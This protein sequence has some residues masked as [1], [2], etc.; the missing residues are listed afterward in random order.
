MSHYLFYKEVRRLTS[1]HHPRRSPTASSRTPDAT[2][3]SR[4]QFF[5]RF[6]GLPLGRLP[7]GTNSHINASRSP[8]LLNT[9]PNQPVVIFSTVSRI[10]SMLNLPRI[11]ILNTRS[12]TVSSQILLRSTRPHPHNICLSLCVNGHTVPAYYMVRLIQAANT[13]NRYFRGTLLLHNK[14]V[15]I[16]HV[17]KSC[18]I[19]T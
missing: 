8:F 9:G 5:H 13:S 2:K 18:G 11:S 14:H 7:R 19:A 3:S 16:W 12:L 1:V 6:F 17:K 4:M 15:T 10:S